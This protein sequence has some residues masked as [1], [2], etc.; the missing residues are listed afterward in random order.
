MV[1]ENVEI[2]PPTVSGSSCRGQRRGVLQGE[3]ITRIA[4]EP[5]RPQMRIGLDIDQLG[6]DAD[7]VARPADAAFQY[8]VDAQFAFDLL[9]VGP[10][11]LIGEG[12]ITRDH[13][14]ACDPRQISRQILGDA[15]REIL[16]LR[17]RC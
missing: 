14:H 1:D 5:L 15:V 4:I 17:C 2:L 16:L 8:I 12:G 10:L 9:R 7:L 13:Q 3:Q 6:V 11:V